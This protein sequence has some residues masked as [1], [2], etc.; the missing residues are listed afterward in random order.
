MPRTSVLELRRAALLMAALLLPASAWAEGP[1]IPVARPTDEIQSNAPSTTAEDTARLQA[2]I[3]RERSAHDQQDREQHRLELETSNLKAKAIGLASKVQSTELAVS[4]S[5]DNLDVLNQREAQMLSKL[6]LDRSQLGD[7][8]A[9]LELLEKQ[10]PPA[11]AVRPEDA[12]D[13]VRSAILLS[14]VVP[15]LR[16][17]AETLAKE[18]K[19]LQLV[20]QRA[21]E[22]H[23][24][25][26]AAS[27]DLKAGR[28]ALA[29]VVAARDA[30]RLEL[31][32]PASPEAQKAAE[33]GRN[34]S[35]LGGLVEDL[36][37]D[38]DSGQEL[39][40]SNAASDRPHD[41]VWASAGSSPLTFADAKGHVRMPAVGKVVEK[42]G[43]PNDSG[44]LTKGIKIGTRA[45]AQVVAPFDGLVKYAGPL[46]TY[47]NVLIVEA[48]GNYLIILAG[49]AHVD[50]DVGQWLLAG[51]PIGRMAD[52]SEAGPRELYLEF[53]RA[54]EPFDPLPW[55]A[56]VTK[57]G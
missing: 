26:V 36:K 42:F 54:R 35:S 24:A 25:L 4:L 21:A 43:V 52:E 27:E 2:D 28:E 55:L 34:A 57:E 19:E 22:E 44:G 41:E 29:S 20:R 10:K 16:A 31:G 18:L 9:A 12:T 1:P 7:T 37:E 13:A 40:N 53:R 39:T 30:H 14:N 11:L 50:A 32:L 5:E 3:A 47:G 33:L 46:K 23:K 48:S 8:L 56:G 45:G 15:R 38:P 49:M 6:K 51:E 17:Q